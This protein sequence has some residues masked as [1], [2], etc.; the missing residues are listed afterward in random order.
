MDKDVFPTALRLDGPYP[1]CELNHFTVPR[2]IVGL[3]KSIRLRSLLVAGN[4]TK[5]SGCVGACHSTL[6]LSARLAHSEPGAILQ[7]LEFF[8]LGQVFRDFIYL[9]FLLR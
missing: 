5:H 4:P 1:F 8:I 2:A 9:L 6:I 7:R 3:E